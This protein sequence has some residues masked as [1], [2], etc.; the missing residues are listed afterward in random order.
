M[1]LIGSSRNVYADCSLGQGN[2]FCGGEKQVFL[3]ICLDQRRV[4]ALEKEEKVVES[5]N[6]AFLF[7]KLQ[8]F[9]NVTS[10]PPGVG[11][12]HSEREPGKI[13]LLQKFYI[14]EGHG[15]MQPKKKEYSISGNLD[16]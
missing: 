12:K 7:N 4:Q 13:S 9:V 8:E 5:P 2:I 1:G 11:C 10:S 3:R 14:C 16:K 6:I 15:G